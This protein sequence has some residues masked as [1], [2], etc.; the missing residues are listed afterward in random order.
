MN[1]KNIPGLEK[2]VI[3][4]LDFFIK[5]K[6]LPINFKKTPLGFVVGSVNA[7]NTGLMLFSGQPA[8]FANEGNF[9]DMLKTYRYLIKNKTIKE[10]IIISASGEKDSLWE[11]K[12]ARRAGLKTTLLT[13]NPSSNG[14]KLA[15]RSYFFKKIAEPYSYN[16]S[17]YLGML[18]SSTQEDPK[19]IKKF[20]S[21]LKLPR[22]KRYNYFSF[23]L[24]N[25]YQAIAEMIN[26]KDDELFGPYSCLRAYTF[27]SARHAKFICP[28]SKELVISFGKN[29]YFGDKKNRHEIAL[30]KKANFGLVLSL[31]YYLCGLIQAIRPDHFKK[32]LENYCLKTGPKPY[33]PP[34]PFSVIVPE[35]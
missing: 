10:A 33:Q 21:T 18:L 23:I 6:A 4:G 14:A 17:T 25:K 34:K 15:D 9:Q 20:L 24:P 30:P 7:F 2:I 3:S 13:C 16:F 26:V 5:N 19:L 35:K 29:D 11:I 1:S 12:A 27:G 8:L 22:L 32:N 28:S 31:S